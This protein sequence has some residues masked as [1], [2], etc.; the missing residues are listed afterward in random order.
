MFARAIWRQREIARGVGDAAPYDPHENWQPPGA[1]RRRASVPQS[2]GRDIWPRR[3]QCGGRRKSVKKN[4]A[5]LHFLAFSLTDHPFGVPRGEQPLGRGLRVAHERARFCGMVALVVRRQAA[6]SEQRDFFRFLFWPQKRKALR[7]CGANSRERP[8]GGREW[9]RGRYRQGYNP[10]VTA[11]PCQPFGP[12]PLCRC[13]TSP[14]TAGSH[15]LHKGAF[16]G[17]QQ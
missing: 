12:E 7:K 6:A 13:A 10:S 17:V 14:H 15:P 1:G 11:A 8:Q 16:R 5:L 4:A 3:G 2:E 9:E